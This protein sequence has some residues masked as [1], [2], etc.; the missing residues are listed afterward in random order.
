MNVATSK[1]VEF[2]KLKNRV[3]VIFSR[4]MN[5]FALIADCGLYHAKTDTET[6]LFNSNIGLLNAECKLRAFCE[7]KFLPNLGTR[8]DRD[9]YLASRKL[10]CSPKRW[11]V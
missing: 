8:D 5:E 11:L 2:L 7:T 3:N 9:I 6:V 1:T 4:A 10:T